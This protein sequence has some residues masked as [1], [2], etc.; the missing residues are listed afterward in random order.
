MVTGADVEVAEVCRSVFVCN[1]LSWQRGI[2]KPDW[3]PLPGRHV[4]LIRYSFPNQTLTKRPARRGQGIRSQKSGLLLDPFVGSADKRAQLTEIGKIVDSGKLA[5][6]ID[7]IFRSAKH[8][9][10]TS[11][12][13]PVTPTEKLF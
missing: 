13:N 9:T 1:K 10:R 5:P 12:V 3:Q 2:D 11:S 8:A 7:R 6:I 4:I